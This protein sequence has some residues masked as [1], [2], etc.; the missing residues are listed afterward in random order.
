MKAI[1][2]IEKNTQGKYFAFMD[3][4]SLEFGITGYGNT[5][6]EAKCDFLLA[7]EEIKELFKDEG[8]PIPE[9]EFEYKFDVASFLEH[10]SKVLSLA[11]LGRLTGVAQGQ[12]SHYVTGK[13]KPSPKT[14][15]KIEKS[16]HNFASEI[17]QVQLV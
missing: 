1:A 7:Y 3:N 2:I 8:K 13:R 5:V 12:F 10:Y 17:S 16:L 4:D 11:G 14:V 6:E 9:L 15:E